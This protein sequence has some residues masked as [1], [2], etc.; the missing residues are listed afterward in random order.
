M[1]LEAAKQAFAQ[2]STRRQVALAREAAGRALASYPVEPVCLRLLNHGFNTTFRVDCADGSKYAVRVNINSRQTPAK[3]NAEACWVEALANVPGVRTPRL[4][5]TSDGEAFST[6][7]LA[8]GWPVTVVLYSWLPGRLIGLDADPDRYFE[9]GEMAAKMHSH[10]AAWEIPEGAEFYV[11]AD[12][13]AGQPWRLPEEQVFREVYERAAAALGRLVKRPRIPIHYDLHLWN[14]MLCRGKVSVFDFDD[15]MLGWPELDASV[16]SFYYRHGPEARLREAR[17]LEGM[18]FDQYGITYADFEAL[19]A[20][21][22]LLLANDLQ[23]VVTAEIA[24]D[25]SQWI[26]V[27]R[28]R[29]RAYLETGVFDRSAAKGPS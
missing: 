8:P 16:A 24:R 19:V 11:F 28:K 3:L 4:V 20:S 27:S 22:Q 14:V 15:A 5:R 6:V 2:L 23:S 29:F 26:E 1:S 13:L 12:P 25:A 9:L 10:A 21:R 18:G 7:D 17:F